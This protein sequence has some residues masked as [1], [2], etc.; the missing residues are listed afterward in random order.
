M[1]RNGL[2]LKRFIAVIGKG[3][4]GKSTIIQS[5]TGCKSHNFQDFV[6]DMST[7]RRIY[8]HAA[9]PQEQPQKNRTDLPEF[10]RQ[11]RVVLRDRSVVGAVYAIQPTNPNKRLS[12]DEMLL[13]VVK[14]G[15]FETYAFILYPPRNRTKG[16][17][18]KSLKDL[19]NRVESCGVDVRNIHTLD[20]RKFAILNADAIRSIS[21]VPY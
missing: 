7:R 19:L 17:D 21:G 6:P 9:S 14:N 4:S 1:A 3:R 11:L 20:G 10:K 12:L 2:V 15:L 13:E 16:S 5:L 8:V 18:R